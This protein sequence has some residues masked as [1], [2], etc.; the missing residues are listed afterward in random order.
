VEIHLSWH[1]Y[2]NA[3]VVIVRAE[4]CSNCGGVGDLR[5]IAPVEMHH[6]VPT[7]QPEAFSHH[8]PKFNKK[9]CA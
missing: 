7:E 6:M 9:I 1:G 3:V 2:W 8:L 5:N 4:M